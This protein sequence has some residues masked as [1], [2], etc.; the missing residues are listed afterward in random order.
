MRPRLSGLPPGICCNN[1]CTRNPLTTREVHLLYV[2]E[3]HSIQHSIP[4]ERCIFEHFFV[5]KLRP[6]P[7]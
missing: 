7:T 5:Y 3:R 4:S 6:S 1:T 2:Y